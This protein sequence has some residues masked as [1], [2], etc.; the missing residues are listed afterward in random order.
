MYKSPDFSSNFLILVSI[1]LYHTMTTFDVP[2]EKALE[3]IVGKGENAG[4]QYFLLFPHC[5]LPYKRQT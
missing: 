1:T 3:N 2:G 4:K 5:L